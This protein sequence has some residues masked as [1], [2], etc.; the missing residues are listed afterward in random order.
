[1]ILNLLKTIA[2]ISPQNLSQ[3]TLFRNYIIKKKNVMTD[4]LRNAELEY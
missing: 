1:M 4:S 2:Q 3:H